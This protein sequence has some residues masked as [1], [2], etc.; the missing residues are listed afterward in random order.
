M[1]PGTLETVAKLIAAACQVAPGEVR[2]DARLASY[3]IDSVRAVDL[4][5]T[6]EEQLG[7]ELPDEALGAVRTVADLVRLCDERRAASPPR[8]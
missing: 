7:V 8:G 2:P 1:T 3:G 6:L 4:A 5:I